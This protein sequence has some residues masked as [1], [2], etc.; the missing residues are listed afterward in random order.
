[1]DTFAEEV[2]LDINMFDSL[3]KG[4]VFGKINGGVVVTEDW[5]RCGWCK[6]YTRQ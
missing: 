5:G 1:V 4:G 6:V 3:V 2:K